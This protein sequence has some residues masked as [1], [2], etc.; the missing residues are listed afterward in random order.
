MDSTVGAVKPFKDLACGLSSCGVAVMRFDKVTRVYPR[1]FDNAKL[2]F[3]DDYFDQVLDALRQAGQ[4]RRIDRSNIY[5]LGHR[6]GAT[7]VPRISSISPLVASIILMARPTRQLYYSA[8]T[9]LRYLQPLN[10]NGAD[11]ALMT[12]I[13]NLEHQADT[14]DG[15]NASSVVGVECLALGLGATYWL[16]GREMNP[17]DTARALQKPILV[18]QGGRD[19][20]VTVNDDYNPWKS[21]LCER[22]S[23]EFSLYPDL[24][25]V[26]VPGQ[27]PS[28][29][30]SSYSQGNVDRR[31]VNDIVKWLTEIQASA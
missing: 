3:S 12:E 30:C 24:N 20:Q 1:R 18:M 26:F 22:A 31:V 23:A 13:H 6:L 5:L 17:L 7:V 11:E 21:A 4:H 28:S 2:T 19:Y 8:I 10:K 29:P 14:A 25:H 9:Q 27:P 15:L 16:S